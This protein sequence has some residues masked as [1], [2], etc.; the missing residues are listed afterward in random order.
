[1]N[2]LTD[3]I[4]AVVIPIPMLWKLNVNRRQRWS[5]IGILGLGI[6]ACVAACVKSAYLLNYGAKTDPLWQTRNITIW[7]VAE[8]NVGII[9][10]SL[11]TLRP[12][13]PG[14]LGGTNTSSYG[15]MKGSY[16]KESRRGTLMPNRNNWLNLSSERNIVLN[17][18]GQ[19]SY[20]MVQ[21]TA[22]VVAGHDST[23][24]LKDAG[25]DGNNAGI[26]KT[27]TTRMNYTDMAK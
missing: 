16:A 18:N 6:F 3:F 4:F 15:H 2:I 26:T 9:A 14:F 20:E 13:F 19:E 27:T 25:E 7:N 5:L 10:G 12:L 11:P 22:T 8:L 23:S 24:R 21:Y 17:G 1:M